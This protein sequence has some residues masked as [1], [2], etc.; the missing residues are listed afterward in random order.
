MGYTKTE[1]IIMILLIL[2]ISIIFAAILMK[3]KPINCI[4]YSCGDVYGWTMTQ[5][6]SNL[7]NSMHPMIVGGDVIHTREINARTHDFILGAVYQYKAREG[8]TWNYDYIIHSLI[9]CIDKNGRPIIPVFDHSGR[10]EWDSTACNIFIFK[11]INNQFLEDIDYV[12]R[13]DIVGIV[14]GV[15]YRWVNG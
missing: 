12:K 13:N 9:G 14:T 11:G 7:T 3:I 15:E 10:N 2:C 6:V 5:K 1:Y 8:N 4:D